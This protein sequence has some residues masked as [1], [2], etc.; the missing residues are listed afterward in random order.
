MFLSSDKTKR[1]LMYY[2]VMTMTIVAAFGKQEFG[3]VC[4]LFSGLK[5]K[6]QISPNGNLTC[7]HPAN[8]LFGKPQIGLKTPFTSR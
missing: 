2:Y 7:K 1:L 5:I 6:I 8:S 4:G 3:S